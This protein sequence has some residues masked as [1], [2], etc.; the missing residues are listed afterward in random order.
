MSAPTNHGPSVP[1]STATPFARPLYVMA[2][3]VGATCNLHCDYCYYLEKACLH[4]G[5]RGHLLSDELLER[6]VRQYIESQTTEEVLFT[7]HGGEPLLRPL[8]FYEKVVALQHRYA[9]GHRIA[10]S[11]QTNGTLIDGRWAQFFQEQGWLVGVSIDGPEA[12]HDAYR[13]TR[14]GGPSFSK[15]MAGIDKLNRH[16][17]AWNALAVANR[18]NGDHG[19]EFYHFF[20]DIG[21]QYIQ[22]TPVVERL[23]PHSDGR[24][25]AAVDEEG[26]V[27]PFSIR[28]RQWGHFLCDICDEW[29][30]HDVSRYYI[31]LF[32]VTLAN[33]V[34]VAPGICTMAKHCGHAGVMEHNGDVY[35]C[36][37]F[38]FPEYK[39]GNIREQTLVEMMYG[40]RQRRFGQAK[41]ENLPGQCRQCAWLDLCH[42]ECPRNRFARTANGQPGLNYLCEGYQLFF[43]HTAPYMGLMKRLLAQRRAPAEIMRLLALTEQHATY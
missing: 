43:E 28:P 17:V 23:C 9:N 26:E 18:L 33:L 8:A 27:A 35:P 16:G 25:L 39:L 42:G 12:Y 11:L 40:E 13:H 38:V 37:H 32:D 30:R 29:V 20:K 15:V 34:G 10:N 2:K 36:D 24:Q 22:I 19:L 4:E 41:A 14:G 21:C 3:P 6:F 5:G 31:N 7:W 1:H